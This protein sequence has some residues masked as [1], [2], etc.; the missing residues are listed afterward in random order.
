MMEAAEEVHVV[1]DVLFNRVAVAD[2]EE[3]AE[4][5]EAQNV[6]THGVVAARYLGVFHQA[7]VGRKVQAKCISGV[8][9]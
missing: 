8:K 2:G 6:S 1:Q 5:A 3:A 9:R 4:P 7:S